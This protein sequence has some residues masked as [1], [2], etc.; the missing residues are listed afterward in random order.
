M[1][2]W[3]GRL[4]INLKRADHNLGLPDRLG[5]F[6]FTEL[7]SA[8][9]RLIRSIMMYQGRIKLRKKFQLDQ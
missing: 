4:Q 3:P 6:I 1:Q 8:Y 2:S 9:I 5:F 7:E